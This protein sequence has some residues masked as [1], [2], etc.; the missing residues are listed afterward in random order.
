MAEREFYGIRAASRAD[1]FSIAVANSMLREMKLML[2]DGHDVNAIA[3]YCRG[4]A[5][6]TAAGYGFIRSVEFL[7][8]AGANLNA[9]DKNDLTP[10]M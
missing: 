10:L 6:N 4:T 2:A 8:G 5:L 9:T 1:A 7:I 3:P